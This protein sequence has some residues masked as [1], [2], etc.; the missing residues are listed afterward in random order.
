[1]QAIEAIGTCVA[2]T[3]R[4]ELGDEFNFATTARDVRNGTPLR[5]R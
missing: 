3:L 5:G 1:M 2:P 4:R